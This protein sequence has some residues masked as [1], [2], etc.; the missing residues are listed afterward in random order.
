MGYD[1]DPLG[2]CDHKTHSVWFTVGS[3]LTATCIS[4]SLRDIKP[5]TFLGHDI[6]RLESLDVNGESVALLVARRTNN[7]PTIGRL[8]V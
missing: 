6:N 7:Q 5:Q 2:S 3:P 4:H 1:L 8:R